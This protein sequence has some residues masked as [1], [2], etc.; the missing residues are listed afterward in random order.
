MRRLSVQEKNKL[1]LK[2]E[3]ESEFWMTMDDFL[4]NFTD[5]ELCH[6]FNTSLFSLKKKWN[7]TLIIGMLSCNTSLRIHGSL[8]VERDSGIM[9]FQIVIFNK[10]I[11]G[12]KSMDVKDVFG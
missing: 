11:S 1:G 2:F 7:E 12:S 10:S 4:Y 8:R 9:D 5:L 6:F 3:A